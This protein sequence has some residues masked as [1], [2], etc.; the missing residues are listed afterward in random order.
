MSP[1]IL[2]P[3]RRE[4]PSPH[5]LTRG[6]EEASDRLVADQWSISEGSVKGLQG[7]VWVVTASR[8]SRWFYAA[9]TSRE[10]AWAEALW[11]AGLDSETGDLES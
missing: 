11:K 4:P 3:A 6:I 7:M 1:H 2:V 9:G 5:R 8:A 10:A